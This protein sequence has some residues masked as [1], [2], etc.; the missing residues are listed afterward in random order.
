M[1]P[2]ELWKPVKGF[3]HYEVSNLG[4]IRKIS[5]LR[6]N[7]VKKSPY[8]FV[9][10]FNGDGHGKR[11]KEGKGG[12]KK[13]NVHRLVADHFV[14]NPEGKPQVNHKNGD[15]LNNHSTNLEWVTPN[16]NMQHAYDTGLRWMLQGP[17]SAKRIKQLSES[18]D[19]I[20][21]WNGSREAV[22]NGYTKAKIYQACGQGHKYKG[23]YWQYTD[24]YYDYSNNRPFFIKDNE[25]IYL[26]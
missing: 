7:K 9:Q 18:G 15:K 10:L 22:E 12:Y 4:R 21:I 13:F 25:R 5:Y 26:N 3:E 14:P 16:E 11:N 8:Q 6:V 17:K 2:E 20:R 24:D 19:T 1:T 23:C